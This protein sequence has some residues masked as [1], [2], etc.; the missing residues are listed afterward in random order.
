MEYLK[1]FETFRKKEL[2]ADGGDMYLYP[3][4][5]D[6]NKIIKTSDDYPEMVEHHANFFK[7]RPDIYP[8]VYKQTK[9][10]LILEKL[11]D[12]KANKDIIEM[13][14]YYKNKYNIKPRNIHS[15][16]KL[17]EHEFIEQIMFD[18]FRYRIYKNI[19]IGKYR[20]LFD[21]IT[22][23]TTTVLPLY[24]DQEIKF[25]DINTSNFGYTKDGVLKLLDV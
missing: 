5:Q 17:T 10:Y 7:K 24:K 11:D 1:L 22:Y 3:Y 20:E 23:I 13:L 9:N 25:P 14:Y 16:R 6:D 19:V 8:I 21:R 15:S 12:V 4:L 18:F 2:Y